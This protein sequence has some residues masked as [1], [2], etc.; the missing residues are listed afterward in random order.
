MSTAKTNSGP[1]N[2]AELEE[3]LSRPRDADVA[4]AATLEGD[5]LITGAGGKMGPSLARLAKR[6]AVQG[7]GAKPG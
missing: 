5:L 1:A 6:S 3:Y 7:R 4:H 2:E